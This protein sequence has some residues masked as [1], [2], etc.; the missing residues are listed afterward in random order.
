MRVVDVWE[1]REAIDTF[2][3]TQLGPAFAKL[4]IAEP[5]Q[6]GLFETFN[7]ERGA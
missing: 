6:P 1:A 7:V 5:S 4:G 2:F 3:E